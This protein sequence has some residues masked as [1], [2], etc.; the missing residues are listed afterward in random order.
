MNDLKRLF[1]HCSL[2]T[3]Q[4]TAFCRCRQREIGYQELGFLEDHLA[5]LAF[6]DP[7]WVGSVF[8]VTQA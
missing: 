1:S 7:D 2:L 8:D 4:V 3:V 5:A 6:E